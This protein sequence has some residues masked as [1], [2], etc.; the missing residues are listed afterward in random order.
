MYTKGSNDADHVSEGVLN[1][2][3]RKIKT[4]ESVKFIK[5]KK[6]E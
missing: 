6:E 3:N 1:S 5:L 2:H 4:Y